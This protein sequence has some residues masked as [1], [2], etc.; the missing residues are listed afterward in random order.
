MNP[1]SQSAGDLGSSPSWMASIPGYQGY[2]RKELRRDADHALRLHLAAKLITQRD[3]LDG[4]KLKLIDGGGLRE[5][6]PFE[7]ASLKLQ[8]LADTIKTASYGYAGLFDS[9]AVKEPELDSLMSFDQALDE[10]VDAI[11]AKVEA[12]RAA[13]A[14]KVG[15]DDSISELSTAIDDL[16]A[17]FQTRDESIRTATALPA[18]SPLSV[19]DAPAEVSPE[20]N[21]IRALRLND[22]VTIGSNNYVVGAREQAFLN[23]ETHFLF[24]LDGGTGARWLWAGQDERSLAVLETISLD[25]DPFK[26]EELTISADVLRLA[27]RGQGSVNLEGPSGRQRD[28]PAQIAIF[29][30]DIQALWA[31]KIGPETRLLGGLTS[32]TTSVQVFRR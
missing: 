11:G 12:V 7:R 32:D 31:E 26:V 19:L 15:V 24:R 6:M 23:G 13:V 10:Q 8:T 30:S 27:S 22:A 4:T 5:V 21:G 1:N 29:R 2:K 9:D 3:R 25:V 16:T 14:G 18:Q 28:I 17:A 20:L